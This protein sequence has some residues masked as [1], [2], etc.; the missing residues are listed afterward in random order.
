MLNLIDVG[1]EKYKHIDDNFLKLRYAYQAIRLSHY[2]KNYENAVKYYDELVEN[3][4]VESIVKYWALSLKAGALKHLGNIAEA[5][6]YFA[7]VFQNC[8]EQRFIASNS[9]NVSFKDSLL[10]E[11]LKFCKNSDEKA[12]LWM[13][14]E[15]KGPTTALEAM[16]QIYE[17]NPKSPYLD[18]LLSREVNRVEREV[19]PSSDYYWYSFKDYMEQIGEVTTENRELEKEIEKF[20]MARK[21]NQ[22]YLWLLAAGY[23]SSLNKDYNNAKQ[24]FVSAYYRW[25]LEDEKR[26][27]KIKLFQVLNEVAGYSNPDPS[28]EANLLPDLEWLENYKGYGAEDAFL[29]IRVMMAKKYA[30][31]GDLV[32]THLWLGDYRFNYDLTGNPKTEPIDNLIS[33]IENPYKTD[34]ENFLRSIYYCS[35]NKLYQ[36]KATILISQH[37]FEEAKRI[38]DQTKDSYK[39]IADP[40]IIHIYDCHDCDYKDMITGKAKPINKKEFVEKMLELDSLV[41]ADPE[42]ASDYYFK[43]A[44]GYYNISFYGNCWTASSFHRDFDHWAYE[45]G[46]DWEF[47]DCSKAKEYYLKAS[48]LSDDRE[49]KAECYLM[50]AKC[51]QNKNRQK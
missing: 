23:I 7:V 14:S 26:K 40:F 19:L 41:K 31:A 50:A 10:F 20:A 42:N 36:I 18:L 2:A 15:F 38:F 49:F 44:N 33:F 21:V 9:L 5:N 6:Y 43:M 32:K 34:Y 51:E 13:L 39:L 1:I 27:E 48:E 29:T 17:L 25:P 3:L 35:I 28:N 8:P 45:Q 4:N 30:A 24:L 47:Y 22:P 16:K 12:A 11:S 46:K 37:K